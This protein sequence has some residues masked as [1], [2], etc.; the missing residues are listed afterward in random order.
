MTALIEGSSSFQELH[1]SGE[2]VTEAGAG[3]VRCVGCGYAIS[4]GA[5]GSLPECPNCGGRQ[6]RRASIF[7]NVPEVAVPPAGQEGPPEWLD[8]VRAELERAGCYLAFDEEDGGIAV[9]RLD[10]GWTRIGRSGAADIRLDHP[11]V[12]RRHALVVATPGEALRVLDDRSLNGLFVNGELVEWAP[13]RRRRRARDRSLPAARA[14]G[15]SE[16]GS[17]PSHRRL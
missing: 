3:S 15:L 6:F 11:T 4:L 9:V 14:R 13:V 2:H 7:A 12:S 8:E 16:P 5:V 1:S 10:D 17:R